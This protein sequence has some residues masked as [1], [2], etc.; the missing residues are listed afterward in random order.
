MYF[1]RPLSR[2]FLLFGFLET[3][4]L[5]VGITGFNQ[6]VLVAAAVLVRTK[7]LVANTTMIKIISSI[8][9]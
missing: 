3:V 6:A 1:T 2:L 9:D 8:N 4:T 5:I 7:G